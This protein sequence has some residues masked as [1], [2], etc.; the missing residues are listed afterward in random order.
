MKRSLPAAF[1]ALSAL[2]ISV[3]CEEES[4]NDS[5]TGVLATY[6][7]TVKLHLDA[8]C[9][10]TGC[11]VSMDPQAGFDFSTYATAS[12]AAKAQGDKILCAIQHKAGCVPMPPTGVKLDASV[13][14]VLECWIQ[15]GAPQ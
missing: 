9:A 6:S 7:T 13:V 10:L 3:S 14:K 12:A 4:N 15:N 8:S 5:C 2:I 1:F 11:H